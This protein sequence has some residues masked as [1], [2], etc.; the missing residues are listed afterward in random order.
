MNRSI[1]TLLAAV[2]AEDHNPSPELAAELRERARASGHEVKVDVYDGAG[3]AFFNTQ[4]D[5]YRPDQ[6]Q[7]GW[8]KVFAFFNRYLAASSASIAAE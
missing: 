6:A 3:H 8:R 5:A 7:D 2:G 1:K 4:R